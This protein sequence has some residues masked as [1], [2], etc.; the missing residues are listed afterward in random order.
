LPIKGEVGSE[1][2]ALKML[3]YACVGVSGIGWMGRGVRE[4]ER[5]VGKMW[6]WG[7]V[8]EGGVPA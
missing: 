3:L 2:S 8:G 1:E 6:I 5:K 4:R 7:R